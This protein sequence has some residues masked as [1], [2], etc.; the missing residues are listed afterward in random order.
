[1]PE[2]QRLIA[3]NQKQEYGYTA[4]SCA[5]KNPQSLRAI[6]TLLPESVRLIAVNEQDENGYTALS[7][8]VKNPD[9]LHTIL[10]LLPEAER[11]AA[12]KTKN[13]NRETIFHQA[14]KNFESMKIALAILPK[15]ERLEVMKE[16]DKYGASVLHCA[17]RYPN[18]LRT[19]LALYPAPEQLAAVKEKDRS[20]GIVL[21]WVNGNIE[22]IKII[23]AIYPKVE[24]LAAAKEI[25]SDVPESE[26]LE[27]LFGR[28]S[29]VSHTAFKELGS[30]LKEQIRTFI[31]TDTLTACLTKYIEER[32]SDARE[33]YHMSWLTFLGGGFTK[34]DKVVAARTLI[35]LINGEEETDMKPI[36]LRALKQGKLGQ[37]I[38]QWETVTAINIE[39]AFIPEEVVDAN[40]CCFGR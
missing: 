12:V 14:V 37:L 13:M 16:K 21:H 7:W 4:L 24:R 26:R 35:Q 11:Q 9:A 18:S 39:E 30:D 29:A 17:A 31:T 10:A 23:L 8:A 2:E 20:G 38:Q 25:L 34:T 33:T 22:S 28:N 15:V 32:S 27:V 1:M 6:L 5:V 3:V 40:R 36:H 19:I